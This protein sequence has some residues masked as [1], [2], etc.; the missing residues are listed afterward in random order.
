MAFLCIN[1]SIRALIVTLMLWVLPLVAYAG[2]FKKNFHSTWGHDR[3]GMFDDGKLLTLTLDK[4]S[5]SGFESKSRYLFGKFDMKIKLVPR[6]SAGTVTTFF[7]ASN[8]AVHDEI[9]FEFLGNVTGEPY[10]IHTNVFSQGKGNREQQFKLWF[11]PTTDFHT[12]S[13]TWNPHNIIFSIDGLPIREF[14]N[15]GSIG[16]PYPIS[17]PMKIYASLWNAD[18]WATMG[19]RVKT[20]WKEAP[21]VASYGGFRI[22]AC[23]WARSTKSTN[24]IESNTN[25]EKDEWKNQQVNS[26]EKKWMKMVQ[27]HY[28]VYN[29][30]TD[31]NRFP[32][33]LPVECNLS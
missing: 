1:Y 15:R 18:D 8:G 33:G 16:V 7:L 17:K 9:D 4:Y 29:Y 2:N 30:C 19:G 11:D 32:K 27:R 22:T 20:N 12:Y 28:M 10:T 21:F 24:C 6:N 13:I 14:K 25:G 23:K 5:G 26:S 3:V 31:L